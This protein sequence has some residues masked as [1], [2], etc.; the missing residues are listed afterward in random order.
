[1]ALNSNREN[2][3]YSEMLNYRTYPQDLFLAS[4]Q[5]KA[6]LMSAMHASSAR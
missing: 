6:E 5:T 2:A 3:I 4:D 1:M